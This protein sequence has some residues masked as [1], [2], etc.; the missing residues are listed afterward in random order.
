MELTVAQKLDALLK[1]QAID[2]QLND[3]RKMRGDLPE[4]V[5]DLEDE[6]AG[7]E[8]RVGKFNTEVSSLQEEVDRHKGIKKDADKLIARYKEQQMNVRNNREFDAITKEIELQSLEMELS[9]KKIAESQFR[10]QSKQEEINTTQQS[11]NLRKEDL[12]MKKQELDQLVAESE[13]DEKSLSIERDE[14]AKNVE[15]RLLLSYDKIRNNAINGLAVVTVRRGACGGCF[16][17]VP[18]QRQADIKDKKK[19]IVCEHC[20][21]ILADVDAIVE[22]VAVGRGR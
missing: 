7:F 20:G 22:P 6:I 14:Q 19:I 9:D 5:R 11:L 8:T 10:M 2:S 16:N 4:E 13:A 17:V 1:L 21:R 18:P 3:I 15:A 12:K